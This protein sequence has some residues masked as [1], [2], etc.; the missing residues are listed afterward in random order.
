MMAKDVRRLFGWRLRGASMAVACV[1]VLLGLLLQ[2][3]GQNTQSRPQDLAA[4]VVLL[5][6]VAVAVYLVERLLARRFQIWMSH[7]QD[8]SLPVQAKLQ[9]LEQVLDALPAGLLLVDV[10]GRVRLANQRLHQLLSLRQNPFGERLTELP[11]A[12]ELLQLADDAR[13]LG[14]TAHTSLV[15]P[16]TRHRLANR[17]QLTLAAVPLDD[18]GTL[19]LMQDLTEVLQQLESHRQLVANV[20]HELKTPLTAIR[21]YAETLQDGALE[22]PEVAGLFT[23]RIL[24]QCS[25]LEDVLEDLLLVARLEN[26]GSGRAQLSKVDLVTCLQRALEVVASQAQAKAVELKL[27][28]TEAVTPIPGYPDELDHLLLNLLD[29]SIKYNRDGGRVDITVSMQDGELLLELRDTGIGIPP[30]DLRRIFERF[31]R[32]DKGRSRQQGGTGL[33]LAIVQQVVALHRGTITVDSQLGSG[34]CFHVRLPASIEDAG[35]ATA[36]EPAVTP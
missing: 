26:H 22:R 8:R 21:G 24:E 36:A 30:S 2:R 18:G 23:D 11:A 25:R 9:Q 15:R 14:T 10:E 16:E 33:G 12:D 13:H 5:L 19:I 34:S 31:Y 32:V 6:L 35:D 27:Q 17:R 3:P 4:V 29:N 7:L 1:G 20:S 28:V